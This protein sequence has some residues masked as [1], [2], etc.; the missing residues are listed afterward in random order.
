MKGT[1]LEAKTGTRL[2]VRYRATLWN[3]TEIDTTSWVAGEQPVGL[4]RLGRNRLMPGLEKGLLGMKVG[5]IRQLLIPPS[6]VGGSG[7]ALKSTD[8]LIFIV[9]LVAVSGATNATPT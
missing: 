8:T 5:G 6:E 4:P 7:G 1:G 3:G 2:Y 9:Q